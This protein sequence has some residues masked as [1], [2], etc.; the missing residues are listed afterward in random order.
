V[1][2][3]SKSARLSKGMMGKSPIKSQKKKSIVKPEVNTMEQPA[4]PMEDVAR[5]VAAGGGM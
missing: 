1:K 2:L 3:P 5:I 4:D